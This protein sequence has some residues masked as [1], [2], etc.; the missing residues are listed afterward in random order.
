MNIGIFAGGIPPPYFIHQLVFSI[1]ERSYK[2]FLYGSLNGEKF[3]YNNQYIYLRVKPGNKVRLFL[4]TL[5]N[6]IKLFYKYGKYSSHILS[7]VWKHD[8]R[9]ST[10]L[11]RCST[12]LPPF[13][14][15]LDI[16][17]IQWAKTLVHYPEFIETL[18]C[19]VLLSLR[20][21][22]INYS[23]LSDISLSQGYFKYFPKVI[24]FHAVSE[25]IAKEA[26]KYGADY[27]KITVIH[28]AVNSD[29]INQS[30]QRGNY[31]TGKSINII[32]IGRCHWKKGYTFALDA[33]DI[34]K[35]N[36]IQFHYTIIASGKDDENINYQIN[37]LDLNKFVTF[38][39]GLPHEDIIRKLL[40]SDLF[41]LPSIE[42]GISNA[43]LEAMALRIPVISTD[44]GGMKEVIKNRENG[45]IVPVR[46][47]S[48]MA[49]E[50]INFIRMSNDEKL[51][52]VNNASLTINQYYLLKEQINKMKLFY[53]AYSQYKE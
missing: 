11:K 1:A 2:V 32:S 22:H 47:S 42:E 7:Q 20:G 9:I 38:I 28:P 37:D 16:F 36:G 19:P 12:V 48:F 17:H 27:S 44:C 34:L 49:S 52:I 3:Y 35:K 39:N 50:I 21:A 30:L 10:F 6:I 41:I 14:D 26:E 51:R 33:M 15:D 24:G 31:K 40:I 43:V 53:G 23:P 25:T 18:K 29:L 5:I 45:F 13:L 8:N 46:E 4:L